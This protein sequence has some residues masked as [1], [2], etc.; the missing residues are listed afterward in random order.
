MQKQIRKFIED[1]IR[2]ADWRAVRWA[3]RY[4]GLVLVA[5][6][7][8]VVRITGLPSPAEVKEG[9]GYVAVLWQYPVEFFVLAIP[10]LFVLLNWRAVAFGVIVAVPLAY[11]MPG[12]RI[13]EQIVAGL[14]VGA[15]VVVAMLL[16]RI[17]NAF[18]KPLPPAPVPATK[19][20]EKA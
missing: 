19:S 15:F 5:A 16:L 1:E 11:V 2:K 6:L 20:M 8:V 14:V 7:V 10:L 4:L 18:A 17:A 3:T 9:L 12:S 13:E